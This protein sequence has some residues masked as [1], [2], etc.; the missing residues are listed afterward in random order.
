MKKIIEV[1]D[2]YFNL[3]EK[4]TPRQ[5]KHKLKGPGGS[6]SFFTVATEHIQSK[7]DRGV[8]SVAKAELS[9]LYNLEEFIN[10]KNSRSKAKI[11]QGIKQRRLK[12]E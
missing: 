6:K 3:D 2:I 4:F 10:L 7:Y 1:N 11:I 8:F 5:I 9:M 12:D